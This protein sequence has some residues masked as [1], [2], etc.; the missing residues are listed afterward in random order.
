MVVLDPTSAGYAAYT[1]TIHQ[2]PVTGILHGVFMPITCIGFFL[3]VSSVLG[4][5]FS[6]WTLNIILAGMFAGY[7]TFD[8]IYGSIALTSYGLLIHLILA[9]LP[10]D[11]K[12][13]IR[14]TRLKAGLLLMLIGLFMME[15]I[16]HWSFEG[17]G[18]NV[19][20][21][22]NSI[23]HTPLYGTKNLLS[24]VGY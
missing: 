8:L 7:A 13:K 4:L 14:W 17:H 6:K 12:A 9:T 22:L 5:R 10:P 11:R 19:L 2:H 3:A 24:L 18:S 16:G 21:L 1:A 20:E 23:Y 15:C